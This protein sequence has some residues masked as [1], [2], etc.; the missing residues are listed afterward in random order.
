MAGCGTSILYCL[1]PITHQLI[2]DSHAARL[3]MIEAGDFFGCVQSC[4]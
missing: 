1:A 3:A 4:V 2:L